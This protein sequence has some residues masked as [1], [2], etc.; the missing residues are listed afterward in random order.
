MSTTYRV[1]FHASDLHAETVAH[2][3]SADEAREEAIDR[4][5]D[6][7]YGGAY[8][9]AEEREEGGAWA[10]IGR[11]TREDADRWDDAEDEDGAD[12]DPPEGSFAGERMEDVEVIGVDLHRGKALVYV[13]PGYAYDDDGA[14]AGPIVDAR[15]YVRRCLPAGWTVDE[16]EEVGFSPVVVVDDGPRETWTF[17]IKRD[18]A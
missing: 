1:R 2:P 10:E 4:A 18:R 12:E 5:R 17:T 7:A 11:W 3:D 6:A 8:Y 15:S 14:L 9:T 16:S 13:V